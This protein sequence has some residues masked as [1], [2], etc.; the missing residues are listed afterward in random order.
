V[1]NAVQRYWSKD[2][3]GV[4]VTVRYIIAQDLGSTTVASFALPVGA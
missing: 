3:I 1:G 2:R 4:E